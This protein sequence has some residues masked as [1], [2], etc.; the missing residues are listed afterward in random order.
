MSSPT[1]TQPQTSCLLSVTNKQRYLREVGDTEEK[2]DSIQ[3]IGLSTAIES[4]NGIELGVKAIYLGTLSI[5]FEA[6]QHNL[7]YVHLL[8]HSPSKCTT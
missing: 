4:C 7:L 3:N 8:F 1:L 5:G 6:V 2:A